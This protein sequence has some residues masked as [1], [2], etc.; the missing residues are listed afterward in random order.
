MKD[1][2]SQINS[3]SRKIHDDFSAPH[4]EAIA[5]TL[6]EG[7]KKTNELIEKV[8]AEQPHRRF[9][10]RR[11]SR[12]KSEAIANSKMRSPNRSA[13]PRLATLAPEQEPVR[14][15]RALLQKSTNVSSR[16][17]RTKNSGSKF[18]PPVPPIFPSKSNRRFWN[19]RI[20]MNGPST[21]PAQPSSTL[22]GN[23]SADLR[24]AVHA[25]PNAGFTRPYFTR[26]DIEQAYYDIVEPKYLT[27]PLAPYPLSAH[28]QFVFDGVPFE[29]SQVVQSVNRLTGPGTVL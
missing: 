23:Q 14:P 28:V 26:P 5:P 1:G 20:K 6:A 24:F 19:L 8:S 2:L 15:I 21:P 18:M 3:L 25:A 7:L 12:I 29:M 22:K 11:N 16:H 17:P 9:Q 10:I 27:R 4:P 13:F